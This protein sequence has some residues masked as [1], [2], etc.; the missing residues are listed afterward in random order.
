MLVL[1]YHGMSE[2]GGR[3]VNLHC[4]PFAHLHEQMHHLKQHGYSVVPWATLVNTADN[5]LRV[6]LTFDDGRKSDL[7]S[8]ALLRSLGYSALFFIAT[9]DIGKNGY[10]DRNDVIELQRLGMGIGSHSHHHV[11]LTPLSD[12]RLETELATSKK[13]L[14]GIVQSPIRTFLFQGDRTMHES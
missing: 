2:T 10:V 11:Q 13:I 8:A 4:L 3:N 14:E 7:E 6:G 1:N 9:N 5:R 12:A